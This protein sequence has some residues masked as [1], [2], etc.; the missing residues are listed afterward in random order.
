MLLDEAVSSNSRFLTLLINYRWPGESPSILLVA[1]INGKAIST[2]ALL[3]E[4]ARRRAGFAGG[5]QWRRDVAAITGARCRAVRC[6]STII[7]VRD[8]IPPL[9]GDDPAQV[10]IA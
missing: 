8:I 1:G 2:A 5:A 6:A 4:F 3:D 10:T 9:I 7:S